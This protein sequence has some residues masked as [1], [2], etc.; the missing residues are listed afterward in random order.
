L[1]ISE[2]EGDIRKY[3]ASYNVYLRL[4][5]NSGESQ[6]QLRD[7]S[8]FIGRVG[9]KECGEYGV[10]FPENLTV[11]EAVLEKEKILK[12]EV[13]YAF[14]SK[15]WGNGYA[16]EALKAFTEAFLKTRGFWDPPFKCVYLHGVT[17]GANSGSRRVLEKNGFKLNG[18]HKW[19][20]PEVFI[21]GA[22]QPPEVCVYSLAPTLGL[23]NELQ[24]SDNP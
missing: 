8:H 22:M 4:P 16:S 14:L 11:P 12:L 18:I 9:A 2:H 20:G 7:P 1:P 6:S 5:E 24:N 10:P 3:R 23:Y 17:G 21:G 13:G 15:A 19:N